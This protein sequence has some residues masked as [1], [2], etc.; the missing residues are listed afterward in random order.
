MLII[1]D[2]IEDTEHAGQREAL[3]AWWREQQARLPGV[4][5]GSDAVTGVPREVS[6]P[7]EGVSDAPATPS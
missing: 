2:D 4:P 7:P 5:P 1:L 3:L 6:D